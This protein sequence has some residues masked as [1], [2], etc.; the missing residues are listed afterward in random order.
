MPGQRCCVCKN[1]QS[2]DPAVSF[3]RFPKDSERR[4]V[5]LE[6]FDVHWKS[7]LRPILLGLFSSTMQ[8]PGLDSST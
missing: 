5:W 7:C 8:G 1:S 3:H 4:S 2:K 6:V